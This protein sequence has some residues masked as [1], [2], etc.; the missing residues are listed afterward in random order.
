M[1]E[2]I[3]TEQVQIGKHTLHYSEGHHQFMHLYMFTGVGKPIAIEINSGR[4]V[5]MIRHSSNPRSKLRTEKRF[6]Y[7]PEGLDTVLKENGKPTVAEMC[8]ALKR[9]KLD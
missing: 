1:P 4:C 3:K 5:V 9:S 7:T 2:Q 8:A 6:D